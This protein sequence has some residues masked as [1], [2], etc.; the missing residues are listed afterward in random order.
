ML[1]IHFTVDLC[2]CSSFCL[3]LT[4]TEKDYE[5]GFNTSVNSGNVP[6]TQSPT[7]RKGVQHT[8]SLRAILTQT[9]GHGDTDVKTV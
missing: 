3:S 5:S 7:T 9:C 2:D 8:G 1:N 6:D 4:I